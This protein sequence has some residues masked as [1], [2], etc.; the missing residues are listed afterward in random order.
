[1]GKKVL[2][3]SSSLRHRSNSEMLAAEVARGARDAG[4]A[5]EMVSLR[6]VDFSFCKGCLAC[7]A[8]GDGH[9]VMR[10]D[11]DALAQKMAKA[12]VLVLATPVYYYGISGQ[13]KALLDRANPLY[14]QGNAFGDVYLVATA[15]EPGERVF[16][17]SIVCLEGWL[18]CFPGTKLAGSVLAGGLEGPG[19][20]EGSTQKMREAYRLGESL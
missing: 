14:G 9:C 20:A 8:R 6:D 3:I 5:V 13:L 17:R 10:D 4:H 11:A 1:M 12:D 15:A 19:E 7:Q 18:D 16:E 2:V